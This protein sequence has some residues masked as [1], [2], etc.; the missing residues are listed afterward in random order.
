MKD[1]IIR[2][3]KFVDPPA[4]QSPESMAAFVKAQN[5]FRKGV[6]KQ[7]FDYFEREIAASEGRSRD[8]LLGALLTAEIDGEKLS[9]EEI[10]DICFL[11]LLA[12]LDT[13]TA[14]LG[15]SI[16]YLAANPEQRAKLVA[17]PEL[18]PAAVEEL[19]RWETP[20]TAVPRRAT[21]DVELRGFKIQE[22][23]IVTLLLGS[24]NTD[25][26]HFSEAQRVD[27][28]RERNLHMAFGAGPHRCLGSHLA[29]MELRVALEEWHRRIPDYR[30]QPGEVP[31][32]T[33]GI[34]EVTYLPWSGSAP[35][36]AAARP[37]QV[38]RPRPLLR[39]RARRLRRGRARPLR[40][41]PCRGPGRVRRAG[42]G[43]GPE[44][45]G[46]RDRAGGGLRARP[47]RAVGPGPP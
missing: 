1:G 36:E 42:A 23:Q 33:P 21:R 28:E 3:H 45:P 9:H 46:G 16:A 4:D 8:D 27:F 40:A 7:M 15:C 32:Y 19:L 47:C 29:R 43:R 34:R 20:V 35:G 37:R 12:G 24:A 5:D 41:H 25:D 26:A 22:G 44:L 31:T 2:A 11:M 10:L 14:T 38:R 39:A 30:I 17:D 13:V 6:A 18:I